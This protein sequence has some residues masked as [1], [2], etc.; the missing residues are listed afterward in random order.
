MTL[1]EQLEARLRAVLFEGPAARRLLQ[2]RQRR[3]D[4]ARELDRIVACLMDAGEELLRWFR[5][6]EPPPDAPPTEPD[7]GAA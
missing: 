7:T 3:P 5:T 4:L 6:L 1:S 2:L